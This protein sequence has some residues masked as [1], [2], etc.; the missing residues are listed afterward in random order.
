MRS[1]RFDSPRRAALRLL[2]AAALVCPFAGGAQAADQILAASTLTAAQLTLVSA[3]GARILDEVANARAAIERGAGVEARKSVARARALL[4]EVRALSPAVRLEHQLSTVI[5]SVRNEK[6]VS[7]DL[8]PVYAELDAIREQEAVADV[9]AKVDEAKR[10]LDAIAPLDPGA[11]QHWSGAADAL[12]EAS[13]RVAYLEIDLPIHETYALLSK[14]HGRLRHNDLR[15]ADAAL[16]K[17]KPHVDGFVALAARGG[18]AELP[19]VGA[20]PAD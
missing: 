3:Q 9:R 16:A 18:E 11:S 8:V 14:A 19:P 13:S 1:H 7:N 2:I 20:G 6:A 17:V 12:I 5:G 10:H 4:G 15:A